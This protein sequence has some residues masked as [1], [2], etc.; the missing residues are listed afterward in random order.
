MLTKSQKCL[1]VT[2]NR[3]KAMSIAV[4]KSIEQSIQSLL[5]F[6]VNLAQKVINEDESINSCEVDIDNLILHALEIIPN[7]LT[8]KELR[9]VLAIQRIN[10]MLERIGDH[11]VNIAESAQNLSHQVNTCNLFEIQLMA[12]HTTQMLHDSLTCFFNLDTIIADDILNRDAIIDTMNIS[13]I[14]DIKNSVL[15]SPQELKFENAVELIRVCKNLERI[16]DLSTN[17]AEETLFMSNGKVVKHH[18]SR[19]PLLFSDDIF[20]ETAVDQFHQGLSDNRLP[21]SS[22]MRPVALNSNSF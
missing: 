21:R 22:P 18:S 2:K 14:E 15:K 12:R 4:E 5:I 3:L 8:T 7:Q 13:I 11:A 17:I 1:E 6:N 9:S 16:A 10:P 20:G 19:S